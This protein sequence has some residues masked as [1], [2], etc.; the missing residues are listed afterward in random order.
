MSGPRPSPSASFRRLYELPESLLT[1][2]YDFSLPVEVFFA[3]ELR[4]VSFRRSGPGADLCTSV[5]PR[6]PF[7]ADSQKHP[8]QTRW[9]SLLP[10]N[11]NY[12]FS[13]FR[14]KRLVFSLLAR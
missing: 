7:G 8:L 9:A 5:C 14:K 11:L 10:V 12:K 2:V 4:M 6:T 13:L 1:P 3:D